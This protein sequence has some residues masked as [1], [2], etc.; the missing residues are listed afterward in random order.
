[1]NNIPER[2]CVKAT[3]NNYKEICKYFNDNTSSNR[4]D[5]NEANAYFNFPNYN[6]GEG[7][8]GGYHVSSSMRDAYTLI[9]FE[10]FMEHIVNKQPSYEIY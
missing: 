3:E 5:R 8:Y 6:N 7:W 4:Y 2:W 9:T 1:M 10:E